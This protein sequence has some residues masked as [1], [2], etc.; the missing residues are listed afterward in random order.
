MPESD[1]SYAEL[2]V[3]E[4]S[5]KE[6]GLLIPVHHLLESSGDRE[7]HFHQLYN[8]PL[9]GMDGGQLGETLWKLWKS[10][11]IFIENQQIPVSDGEIPCNHLPDSAE[12]LTQ[13]LLRDFDLYILGYQ[14]PF[15]DVVYPD[16]LLVYHLTRQG[17]SDWEAFAAPTWDKF[18]GDFCGGREEPGESIWSQTATTR[19]F[20]IRVLTNQASR[21]HQ[22]VSIDWSTVTCEW[23]H[24]WVVC[25]E[26]ILPQGVKVSVQ[27]IE[28]ESRGLHSDDWLEFCDICYW[29][30]SVHEHPDCPTNL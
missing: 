3:L 30:R 9:T 1:L 14:K 10:G 13:R 17:F 23:F 11:K 7:R 4:I 22:P 26:K 19:E 21:W 28:H 27:V 6:S 2:W 8:M 5:A 16:G 18:R 29:Y 15:L 20:A 25:P 24:P 12:S